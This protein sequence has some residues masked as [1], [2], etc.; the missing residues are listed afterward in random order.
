M[1]ISK[2]G[3]NLI[4]SLEGFRSTKY[5]DA[6]GYSIG[7]GTFITK[8]K[9]HL[10]NKKIDKNEASN[11]LKNH[12]TTEIIP[13]INKYVKVRLNQA[14]LD[15]LISFVYN[16]G[17]GAFIN[18]TLLKKINNREPLLDIGNEFLKWDKGKVNGIKK[19]IPALKK[20]RIKER[21]YFLRNNNSILNNNE[22]EDLKNPKVNEIKKKRAFTVSKTF[23]NYLNFIIESLVNNNMDE[24]LYKDQDDDSTND[25]YNYE[26]LF[27]VTKLFSKVM[28][29]SIYEYNFI[30]TGDESFLNKVDKTV[31][32]PENLPNVTELEMKGII[33]RFN[34]LFK[35]PT[36]NNSVTLKS[37]KLLKKY[38]KI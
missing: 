10:Y 26:V 1:D 9:M 36:T 16:V 4:K 12:I 22:K 5:P 17:A 2:N 35:L 28:E 19:S 3:L 20:R 27:N 8:D 37:L 6:D 38:L 21:N 11:L 23:V 18:S 25:P 30:D 34:S 13:Y 33:D 29:Q 15:A 14:Q 7:Y 24:Y 31:Y 32:T